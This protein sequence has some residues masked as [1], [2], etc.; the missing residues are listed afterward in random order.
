MARSDK[1]QYFKSIVNNAEIAAANGDNR[2]VYKS[3]RKLS[4]NSFKCNPPIKA[5]DGKPLGTIEQ[6]LAR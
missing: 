6:Q 3:I 1:R 5:L 4:G 2:E